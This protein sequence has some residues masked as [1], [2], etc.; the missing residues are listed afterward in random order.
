MMASPSG[1]IMVSTEQS[2]DYANSSHRPA[3]RQL[4]ESFLTNSAPLTSYHNL[5]MRN[6]ENC[7]WET[8]PK[9]FETVEKVHKMLLLPSSGACKSLILRSRR[10][11]SSPR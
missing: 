1:R 8:T 6:N 10:T 3:A 5:E 7:L 2:L 11:F 9:P 4:Q